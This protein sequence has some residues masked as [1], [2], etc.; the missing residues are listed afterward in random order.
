MSQQITTIYENSSVVPIFVSRSVRT[1]EIIVA[2]LLAGK[3]F[4][5]ISPNQ[6]KSR[7]V[8]ALSN[9]NQF[10]VLQSSN[11]NGSLEIHTYREESF[12]SKQLPDEGA[13]YILHTSGSTGHPKGVQISEEGITNTLT[14]AKNQGLLHNNCK[15]GIATQFYFDISIFDLLAGLYFNIPMHIFSDAT[16]ANRTLD[17]I[18]E[19]KVNSIF[20]T[21]TFF[22]QFVKW[23]LLEDQRLTP[24]T[25]I[26]SG[27]DFFP[28]THILAWIEKRPKLEIYNVW[29]PTET[30]VVN[31]AYKV[32]KED[33][34]KLRAGNQVSIGRST[35]QMNIEVMDEM[36]KTVILGENGELVVFGSSVGIGYINATKEQDSRFIEINERRGFRT[37]DNGFFDLD[38][39]LYINGRSEFLIKRSGNRIDPREVEASA[40]KFPSVHRSCLIFVE[41][42]DQLVLY[43]ELSNSGEFDSKKHSI[44]NHLRQELPSY[45]VPS[46]LITINEIPLNSN[47]KIDRRK[48]FET[49]RNS[50]DR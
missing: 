40:E 39:Y 4:C 30:S 36:M 15:I 29:G 19:H 20:A 41:E 6:P 48:V 44:K 17:E 9:L 11:S 16:D 32:K 27:G 31:S 50:D 33:I 8:K 12:S 18:S 5:P 35:P 7:I 24:L 25:K 22:S 46:R 49:F 3:T 2:T 23:N 13:M 10:K 1:V 21:P 43:V 14:W 38:G 47:G 42:T 45:M 28:T 34:E 26:I 37:S